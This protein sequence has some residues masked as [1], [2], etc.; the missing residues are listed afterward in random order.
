MIF[1]DPTTSKETTLHSCVMLGRVVVVC[2]VSISVHPHTLQ[3]SY[4]A[5]GSQFEDRERFPR[6]YTLQP[7]AISYNEAY[8]HFITSFGWRR[9]AIIFQVD[10]LFSAVSPVSVWVGECL[11]CVEDLEPCRSES[12]EG[13]CWQGLCMH[14]VWLVVAHLMSSTVHC[15]V[16]Q[17][18]RATM[19]FL[20]HT[21]G[22]KSG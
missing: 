14:C 5:S 20:I 16:L 10:P 13:P 17:P 19:S 2:A 7:L 4:T 9:V 8:V 11:C 12:C 15:I 3:V 18:M 21:D 22:S 1:I 6:L